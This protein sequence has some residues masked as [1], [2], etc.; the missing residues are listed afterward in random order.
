M[1][2]DRN[3]LE[4]LS[5]ADALELLAAHT[6]GRIALTSHALPL[7]LPVNY[8]YD[9]R[10]IVIRTHPGTKLDV[11]TRHA[12]VAFEVD[13]IDPLYHS[14]WS[15]VVQ[16]MARTVVDPDELARCRALPTAVWTPAVADR[17]VTVSTDLVTGR[18]IL[19]PHAPVPAATTMEG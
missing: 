6:F 13:E 2:L 3:G 15:V 4:V 5:R 18:R 8:R 17:Y 1:E 10:S 19:R 16:G 7:V 14:G 12:V 9:G 11:A